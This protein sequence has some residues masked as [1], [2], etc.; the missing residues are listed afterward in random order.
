MPWI[1]ENI[2]SKILNLIKLSNYKPAISFII[3]L[4]SCILIA[5]LLSISFNL[6]IGSF[7][8]TCHDGYVLLPGSGPGQC[9]DVNECMLEEDG[10]SHLCVNTPGS[11]VCRC[12]SPLSL[13]EDQR[14][15]G[16]NGAKRLR[17]SPALLSAPSRLQPREDVH[18][19]P[20]R[21]LNKGVCRNG[22]CQCPTGLVG[23]VCQTGSREKYNF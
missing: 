18:Q 7:V 17:K 5:N 13:A 20:F 2:V 1:Y 10:C 8:C 11:F 16:G 12:P 4:I 19:C 23:N 22:A 15:C 14:T 3:F 9:V 21:C 6:N